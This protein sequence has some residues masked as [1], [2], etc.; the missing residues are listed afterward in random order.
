MS[1]PLP[2]ENR[3]TQPKENPMTSKTRTVLA[4]P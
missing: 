3:S 4:Q 1:R 2:H